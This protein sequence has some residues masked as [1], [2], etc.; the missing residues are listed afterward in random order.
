M[1]ADK[2]FPWQKKGLVY[3]E[4][5]PDFTFA[6]HPCVLQLQGDE[7]L[8]A[9]TRRDSRQYS[10]I[11]LTRAEI[12]NGNVKI[13]EKPKLALQPGPLGS[14]D[15][16]GAAS[17][18]LIKIDSEIYVYYGS[19]QNLPEKG[20]WIA[21]SGRARLNPGQMVFEREFAGPIF[22]RGID[23]PYWGTGPC[24]LQENGKWHVW[25]V[26]LDRWERQAD[27]S[28]KHFYNI[29]HRWSRDAIQWELGRTTSIPFQNELENAIACPSVI[30][31][32]NLYRMWYSFRQQPSIDTYRL[33]Y[34]ESQDGVNWTRRDKM[35]GIDVSESGW[36]S[37][38]ICY[39]HV[40]KH[41]DYYYML[42]NGNNYG[43]TGFGL[44]SFA[45]AEL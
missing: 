1:P 21:E 32:N 41:K 6:S 42:Y 12:A 31:E 29:K 7:F 26:S 25:Y 3:A 27:G 10:N 11:F 13:L 23:E 36:D 15:D 24:L 9:F 20:M 16:N 43:K 34:A 39:A 35:V 18:N 28:V 17:M 38:M 37:Q 4:E 40:F 8:L 14:F 45:A 19:W 44:A 33:G 22:G 2:P 30:K 5:I